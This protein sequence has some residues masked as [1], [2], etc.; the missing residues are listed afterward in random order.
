MLTAG[1]SSGVVPGRPRVME[2]GA[3]RILILGSVVVRTRMVL[4]WLVARA[5][6]KRVDCS[7]WEV[8]WTRTTGEW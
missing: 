6:R 2:L 5:A 4:L 3:L 1:R 7:Y 8:I